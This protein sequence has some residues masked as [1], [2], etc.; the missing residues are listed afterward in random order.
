MS[1]GDRNDH[2]VPLRSSSSSSGDDLEGQVSSV[3]SSKGIKDLWNKL[4][5]RFS[6]RRLSIKRRLP[7]GNRSDFDY[8]TASRSGGGG[9]VA[10]GDET[11]GDGAPP[12]WALLLI[13][14]LLGLA[15][16]LCVAAFNRGVHVIHEWSW[17][18]TPN[19]GAAWLRLQRLGDTWHRILLIPVTGGVIVGVLHGLLEILHQIKQSNPGHDFNL[20]SGV[21]PTVKAIQAAVTLGT[22]CSL[23]P[24][25]P[26]V[27]IGKS[28]ANGFSLMMENNKERR[29]ALV[30]AGAA[31][32]ISSGFNAAVAGC[33]FAIE[34]VLRPQCA[35]NS[36]PFTT[37]MI[38]LA[39]VISSTVSSVILGEKQAFT[40]PSYDLKSAAG[41]LSHSSSI[42]CCC[43]EHACDIK[44]ATGI[45]RHLQWVG[46]GPV[47]CHISLEKIKLPLYLIL[48]MLC[49]V[50]SVL[51]TRL[52]AWFNSAFAYIEETFG[53]PAI[54]S[55]ALGGLGAGLI[56][57]KYPGILYWGFTNIDEILHTGKTASAPGIWL[58]AQLAAAKVVAT[59]LCKGSGLVGGL[60][61]PSL[62]IGAA[63]GAVGMAATL[64]SVCSVPLTSVLL[65]F[66]LTK[67]YR[68]LLPLMG[69]V[70]LAI[71]V[72]SVANQSKEAEGSDTR[73]SSRGYSFLSPID[74][75][76]DDWRQN[77]EDDL[78]LCIMGPG[79]SHEAI[80]EDI[81]LEDLKVSQAMTNSYPKVLLSSTVNE[82]VKSMNDGQQSCVLVVD[83]EDHLEGI[84]TYGDVK[85][86]ILRT[87][88]GS[89]DSGINYRGRKRGLLTCYP[90]TDL[91]IA[92]KLMEAKEIKQLP[93]V[94][95]VVDFQEERKR[96]VVAILYYHSIWSCLREELNRRGTWRT[97]DHIEEKSCNGQMS[98]GDHNDHAVQ[99]RSSSSSSGDDLEGQVSSVRSSKGIKDLWKKLDRRFSG[100]R[101][102]I[103]RRL[104]KGN[105]S[106]FDY[107]T[108]SRSGGGG[109]VAG[110]DE[111]LGDGAPPEWALLLIGCLL[112]LATDCLT[113]RYSIQVHVIHE[114]SWAGTPNEGAAWL[115]LQRLG[116]TWHRILLIPVTGGVI[117]G[118]LHG[119]L[120]IL[121]QIKQ[122]NPGHDFNLLSGV[123]PT[124]KAIQ[125][126][127]TLGTGCSLGPEGP[128]VDIG[129]SCAN[130]FSLMM[131]NNKERRIALVAAGA[132]A[133]ISS[134]FNAAV[135]G[136]FFAIETVL[137]PQFAENSPPFTTAMIILASV[138]SSTVSSVILG[139][140]QAFT[141]PE[142]DLKSAAE[143]P[144]YLILGMLC[145]V[146][147]VLF[148]RLV[149]WFNNTFAYIEERFGLPAIVSPALGGLGAGLIAL[150]YPG[151]LYW[152]FTNV[153]EIL[154]TGKTASAPGIWLLAQLAAAKVVATAL[155][156]GSGLVGGL[157]APSLMIGAAVGAVGMAATLASVCSVPLTSVLLLFELTKDYRILLPLMG[158]VG[159]AIWVPSV[160]NQ[161]K[162]AEGSDTRSSSRGYSF[163]SPID[164]KT[165][166]WRQNGEDDLELCI[167]GPGFSGYV[168][169]LS[170]SPIIIN[171]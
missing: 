147:S 86:G 27:D 20:L 10:G 163:L 117:V 84:L 99:L 54:V 136:C 138:I 83:H 113:A 46:L 155:C 36:P 161:S 65:L 129:K 51:F 131:E 38:I 49:G 7:K 30:A 2:A 53:L 94:Q 153:D 134:G 162:E 132:A 33:F 42:N 139:E 165:D 80:D 88:N 144:L 128:S 158:A 118:V 31:A 109:V 25:G 22:G 63:V 71:W 91:A 133:G 154:H 72:P 156:K 89:S 28:C 111:T 130:G 142:Y 21:F 140:K 23:G 58:L 81:I 66:E 14:C 125:A 150:K 96:R 135:A 50:V 15:T 67:D 164:D 90:D 16:G 11:L 166:D 169:Q 122:S 8:A 18:G 105:R 79:D 146:V 43:K 40:V 45:L 124:V 64:A 6:G 56:A 102:S 126:A 93:V 159:L 121:H 108:A 44:S 110:G 48:G 170:E 87:P 62:M 95:H 77:G 59:A 17:A 39:S 120:E 103:K 68:I 19:E 26:S 55:P 74:D 127:V 151:I 75:K 29:V 47:H 104:P 168:K 69:A 141:V 82:A 60:Y 4:D 119:L 152:G 73:S 137:R 101:L 106:D 114:W 171:C 78:E 13:G 9:V 98:G 145:G 157:Y 70:G 116:D 97:E 52:V 61:A 107:A 1:G 34:T 5:R 149:A 85:R 112:G 100:R 37:A 57:L 12:E 148:T 160:A 92:K 24:E 3:R 32:G 143:L 123:F 115:R 167:M 35:E 76:T 41:I